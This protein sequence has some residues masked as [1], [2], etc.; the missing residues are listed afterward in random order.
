MSPPVAS[1]FICARYLYDVLLYPLRGWLPPASA[2]AGPAQL[3]GGRRFL[4]EEGAG[5]DRRRTMLVAFNGG[6]G[7]RPPRI[8]SELAQWWTAQRRG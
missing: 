8:V 1:R 2:S 7:T 4:Q 6:S 3:G 5:L